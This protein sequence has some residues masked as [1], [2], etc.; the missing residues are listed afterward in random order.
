MQSHDF[1]KR[2]NWR[3]VRAR[4]RARARGLYPLRCYSCACGVHQTPP[5]AKPLQKHYARH[6]HLTEKT[7]SMFLLLFSFLIV[8]IVIVVSICGLPLTQLLL[9]LVSRGKLHVGH[10]TGHVTICSGHVTGRLPF[11]CHGNWCRTVAMVTCPLLRL[12]SDCVQIYLNAG[13]R[14]QGRE[15]ERD[16]DTKVR[17]DELDS[18][19]AAVCCR[20]GIALNTG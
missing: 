10:V 2:E 9:C 16:G 19:F 6:F 4:A 12:P 3:A 17:N 14:Q 13:T 1:G 18:C 5:V 8:I 11:G 20:I 7:S 15:V